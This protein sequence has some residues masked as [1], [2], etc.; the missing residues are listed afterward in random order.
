MHRIFGKAQE[1]YAG[2]DWSV[3]K[4]G[5][6]YLRG[7]LASGSP[8][9][10]RKVR[11]LITEL[12]PRIDAIDTD[13]QINHGFTANAEI[14]AEFRREINPSEAIEEIAKNSKIE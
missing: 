3:N 2:N 5:E 10:Q 14:N 11:D 6:D 1:G 7:A 4:N 12:A 13:Y 8:D 9:I